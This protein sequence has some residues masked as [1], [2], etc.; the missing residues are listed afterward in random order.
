MVKKVYFLFFIF[1]YSLIEINGRD[2]S[3][4]LNKIKSFFKLNYLK[5]Y[6]KNFNLNKNF[7]ILENNTNS[8]MTGILVF[9]VNRSDKVFISNFYNP[10]LNIFIKDYNDPDTVTVEVHF[11]ISLKSKI[12]I[13]PIFFFGD[14]DIIP[15][16]YALFLNIFSKDKTY[17]ILIN[18]HSQRSYK[19]K[20]AERLNSLYMETKIISCKENILAQCLKIKKFL[21]Y[22]NERLLNKINCLKISRD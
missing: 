6:L 2:K 13:Y 15:N 1:L 11:Y 17:K 19:L 16:I 18:E 5:N 12:N 7:I 21:F 10:D 20:F 8:V 22:L 3:E 14:E 4:K 9:I